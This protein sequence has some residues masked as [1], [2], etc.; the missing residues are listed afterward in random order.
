MPVR[1][2]EISKKL[3][4]ENKEVLAKAKELGITAARVPSSSL[5]KIT[6]D[7]VEIEAV[8]KVGSE[9][10]VTFDLHGVPV[11]YNME[12]QKLSCAGQQVTYEHNEG[13]ISLH[14]YVDRRAEDIFGNDGR[15]YM[16]MAMRMSPTNHT[17]K[18][19]SKGGG[20]EIVSLKVHELKSAW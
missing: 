11:V 13:R 12:D 15:L 8:L 7:L 18:L 6:A 4:I 16:P 20:A 17:L 9:G 2:Y 19:S 14:L 10:T 3:G 1:I 5:D